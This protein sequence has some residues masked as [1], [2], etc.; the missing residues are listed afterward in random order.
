MSAETHTTYL[1]LHPIPRSL[2]PKQLMSFQYYWRSCI[3]YASPSVFPFTGFQSGQT[4]S[5]RL[6][7]NT[8]TQREEERKQSCSIVLCFFL[9]QTKRMTESTET[10]PQCLTAGPKLNSNIIKR[11]AHSYYTT[12]P[13]IL[14][15]R[16]VFHTDALNPGFSDCGKPW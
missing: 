11:P 5:C 13:V 10:V 14:A 12:Y 9:S 3:E 1:S 16:G 7:H 15:S 2:H 8:A 4:D 6:W